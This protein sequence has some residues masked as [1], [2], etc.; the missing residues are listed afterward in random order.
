MDYI[1]EEQFDFQENDDEYDEENEF[2]ENMFYEEQEP[3]PTEEVDYI[4]ENQ[5][6]YNEFKAFERT[7]DAKLNLNDPSDLFVYL[8]EQILKKIYPGQ[9]VKSSY[10]LKSESLSYFDL[11]ISNPYAYVFAHLAIDN[12]NITKK[13]LNNAYELLKKN[14][15]YDM[16]NI[17]ID[18]QKLIQKQD[19]FRYAR[20]IIKSKSF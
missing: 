15:W 2:D 1:E 9:N 6:Q 10:I 13:S 14:E 4:N 5:E 17:K 7:G 18:I 12:G 19:L 8:T 11:S 20:Y 16:Y 3:E